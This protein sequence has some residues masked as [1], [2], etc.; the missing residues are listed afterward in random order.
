M[1]PVY[2]IT[3]CGKIPVR[4]CRDEVQVSGDVVVEGSQIV[5]LI[6]WEAKGKVHGRNQD[7]GLREPVLSSLDRSLKLLR[8]DGAWMLLPV[9]EPE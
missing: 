3:L 7:L 1:R 2:V 4:K 9:V 5:L 6:R 8:G